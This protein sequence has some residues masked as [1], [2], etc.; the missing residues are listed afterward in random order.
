MSRIAENLANISQRIH[1]AAVAA[2]REPDVVR[3]LAV[4]KTHSVD[5]IR[6]AYAA[7]LTSLGKVMFKKRFIK[8][9]N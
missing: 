4:S 6:E 8:L 9:Q 7:G 1:S 5:K 3:I 2:G